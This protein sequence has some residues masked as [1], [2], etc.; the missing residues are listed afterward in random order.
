MPDLALSFIDEKSEKI[1]RTTRP[2][3]TGLNQT[4][5]KLYR[6][7]PHVSSGISQKPHILIICL[8]L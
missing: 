7:Q 8:C 5:T 1:T 6:A 2:D 3:V 4:S